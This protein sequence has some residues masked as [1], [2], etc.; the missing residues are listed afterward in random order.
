MSEPQ[1]VSTTDIEKAVSGRETDVLDGLGIDWRAARPHI[2]CPT[3]TMTTTTRHGAG[4]VDEKKPFA[5]A[6]QSR[7]TSSAS[8]PGQRAAISA[9]PN[10]ALPKSYNAM[11]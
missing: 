3:R 1:Y 5:P 8:S 11:T 2:T 9:Q 10:Y 7:K 6:R 4:T